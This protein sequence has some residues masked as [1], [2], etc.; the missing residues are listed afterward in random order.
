MTQEAN[1]SSVQVEIFDQAFNLC[2]P[3]PDHILKLAEYVDAKMRTL[4]DEDH[5]AD[6]A[7]LAM[8]VVAMDIADDCR[9]VKTKLEGKEEEG[10]MSGEKE[11][12]DTGSPDSGNGEAIGIRPGMKLYD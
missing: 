2:G 10:E 7:R 3:D 6:S 11:A 8:L 5:T 12:T 1:D 9:L 4:A